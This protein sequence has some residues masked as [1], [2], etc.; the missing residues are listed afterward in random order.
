MKKYHVVKAVINC[1]SEYKKFKTISALNAYVK[2]VQ[3]LSKKDA[4]GT[5]VDLV[6]LNVTGKTYV[7]YCDDKEEL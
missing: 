4:G 7:N 2:K 1:G 3:K 5:W 6:V